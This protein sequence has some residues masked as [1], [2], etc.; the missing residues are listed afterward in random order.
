MWKRPTSTPAELP[1]P[2]PPLLDAGMTWTVPGARPYT[3]GPLQPGADPAC[4]RVGWACPGS[5]DYPELAEE[6]RH[7]GRGNGDRAAPQ[8]HVPGRARERTQG[9]GP[10]L[11]EDA[12]ALHPDP[13]G[14][15]GAG[16]A[17][18]VRPIARPDRVPL[19]VGKGSSRHEGP[20]VGEEDVRQV[21][22]HPPT[23]RDPCDLLAP[24]AQAAA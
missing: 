9:V 23:R 3:C 2:R 17:F 22:G 14:G 4:L 7:R 15:P 20:S 10:H 16:G 13:P 6:G 12:D 24:A 5:R 18:A 11:G 21:Q 19:Q 8:R 1:V